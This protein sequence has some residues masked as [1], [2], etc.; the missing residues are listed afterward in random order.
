MG[1]QIYTIFTNHLRV[2]CRCR[3]PTASSAAFATSAINQVNPDAT[4]W[5]HVNT[6]AFG[7]KPLW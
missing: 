1:Q 4:A 3:A 6:L 5:R 2:V 7:T